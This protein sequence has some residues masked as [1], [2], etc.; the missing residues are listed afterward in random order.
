MK[1]NVIFL[2]MMT[3]GVSFCCF[4]KWNLKSCSMMEC[5]PFVKSKDLVMMIEKNYIHLFCRFNENWFHKRYTE[6]FFRSFPFEVAIKF[7][8]VSCNWSHFKWLLILYQAKIKQ[9]KKL[10]LIEGKMYVLWRKLIVNEIMY[11]SSSFFDSR[12]NINLCVVELIQPY[13]EVVLKSSSQIT[14]PFHSNNSYFFWI[15][16]MLITI[17]IFCSVYPLCFPISM[18]SEQQNISIVPSWIVFHLVVVIRFWIYIIRE[19]L[20]MC[21]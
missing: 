15:I 1:D 4:D 10:D 2:S 11:I 3:C 6:I 19:L 13:S 21:K 9:Q 7:T 8:F 16:K 5:F 14:V 20:S 17:E 12:P 18:E